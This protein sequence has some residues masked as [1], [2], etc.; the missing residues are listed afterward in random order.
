MACTH[1]KNACSQDFVECEAIENHGMACV[2]VEHSHLLLRLRSPH[3]QC[4]LILRHAPRHPL[5]CYIIVSN[6]P[7]SCDRQPARN[8]EADARLYACMH[9]NAPFDLPHK[10]ANVCCTYCVGKYKRQHSI[11]QRHGATAGAGPS[12]KQLYKK[13]WNQGPEECSN[14]NSPFFSLE[15]AL[16]S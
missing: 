14:K 13:S 16:K 15:N 7:P 4:I 11:L 5:Q 1:L 6:Y 3:F 2:C 8:K 10:E 12:Q 9:I